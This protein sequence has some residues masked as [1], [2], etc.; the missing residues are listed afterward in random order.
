MLVW[1]V[2]S[3][4]MAAPQPDRPARKFPPTVKKLR[5][6]T[7]FWGQSANDAPLRGI[8]FARILISKSNA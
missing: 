1:H 8:T 3:S 5:D 7:W 4:L 6:V 2:C